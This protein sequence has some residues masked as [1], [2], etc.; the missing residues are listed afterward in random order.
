MTSCCHATATQPYETAHWLAAVFHSHR[1]RQEQLMGYRKRGPKPKHLLVQ[2]GEPS[3]YLLIIWFIHV[4]VTSFFLHNPSSLMK[5]SLLVIFKVVLNN[6]SPGFLKI[7]QR[8]SLDIGC[9]FTHFQPS[10]WTFSEE[11]CFFSLLIHL[12]LTY[13]SFK[14]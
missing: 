11:W 5:E 6:S 2:V 13:E 4:Q 7:F 14:H 8:F 12:T 1:E 3:F 9:F 10:T